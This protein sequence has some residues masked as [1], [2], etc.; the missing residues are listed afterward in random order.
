METFQTIT[1]LAICLVSIGQITRDW[2]VVKRNYD[3]LTEEI[4]IKTKVISNQEKII[5]NH[6]KEIEKLNKSVKHLD[7]LLNLGVIPDSILF[8][9]NGYQLLTNKDLEAINKLKQ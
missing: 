9:G 1:L 5:E 3:V 4:K 8:H 6:R 7:S 2:T